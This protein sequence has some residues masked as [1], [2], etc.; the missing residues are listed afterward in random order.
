[1]SMMKENCLRFS[2]VPMFEKKDIF[3]DKSEM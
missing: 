2:I 3:G 1:M